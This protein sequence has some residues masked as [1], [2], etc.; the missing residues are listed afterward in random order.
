[1][2]LSFAFDASYK[3]TPKAAEK[4]GVEKEER[5]R[6]L[7]DRLASELVHLDTQDP[8]VLVQHIGRFFDPSLASD[9]LL[10]WRKRRL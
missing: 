7:C 10:V 9:T 6:V 2:T 5:I 1:M 8:A 3:K 4:G